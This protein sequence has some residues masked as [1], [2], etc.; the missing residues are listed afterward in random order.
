MDGCPTFLVITTGSLCA[1]FI[2]IEEHYFVLSRLKK[3]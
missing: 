3:Q 2:V 1:F